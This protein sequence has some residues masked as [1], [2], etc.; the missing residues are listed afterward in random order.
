MKGGEKM[1]AQK[2]KKEKKVKVVDKDKVGISEKGEYA[3]KV[4]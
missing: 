3:I 4:R 1:T 2:V